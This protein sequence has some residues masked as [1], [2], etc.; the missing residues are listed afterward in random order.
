MGYL[1]YRKNFVDKF[2][3]VRVYFVIYDEEKC[4][5]IEKSKLSLLKL[6]SMKILGKSLSLERAQ[7]HSLKLIIIIFEMF[8]NKFFFAFCL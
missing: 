3:I 7:S 1:S 4:I 5:G 8:I 6:G 2:G